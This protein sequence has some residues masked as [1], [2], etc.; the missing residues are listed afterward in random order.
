M[1]DPGHKPLPNL[2]LFTLNAVEIAITHLHAKNV[3]TTD[4]DPPAPYF[5]LMETVDP[6]AERILR[7]GEVNVTARIQWEENDQIIEVRLEDF[8]AVEHNQGPGL[9]QPTKA[10]LWF[11]SLIVVPVN[12]SEDP[13]IGF[14]IESEIAQ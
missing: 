6:K 9:G 7:T 3:A 2:K 4:K 10:K 1:K 5:L 11:K 12:G 8:V 14:D 13:E